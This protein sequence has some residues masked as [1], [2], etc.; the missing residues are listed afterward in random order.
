M[1]SEIK[2]EPSEDSLIGGINY[3]ELIIDANACLG[4]G[5]YGEVHSGYYKSTKV[6]IKIQTGLS[7]RN[8]R[9]F[10]REVEVLKSLS[11]PNIMQYIGS[12]EHGGGIYIVTELLGENLQDV[13]INSDPA[14]A[15]SLLQGMKYAYDGAVGV[16][17]LHEH[18]PTPIIHRDIKPENFLLNL[19]K[20][21]AVVCDFGISQFAAPGLGEKTSGKRRKTPI[22]SSP[23]VDNGGLITTK[24]D[25]Y[26][27][28]LFLWSMLTRKTPFYDLTTSKYLTKI[29]I[30]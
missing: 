15:P 19:D 18:Q 26:S 11:H 4:A 14:A 2:A 7:V 21:H 3:S 24:S 27:F 20:T 10:M 17:W 16:R 22:W 23:E 1:S 9:S 5:G 28:G 12:C 30:I 13:C 29:F 8:K 25:V 6:A